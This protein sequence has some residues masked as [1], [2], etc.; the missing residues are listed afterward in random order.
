MLKIIQNKTSTW[1]VRQVPEWDYI[2]GFDRLVA[3]LW[4]ENA[5]RN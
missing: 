1:V 3:V 4:Q 2:W 5:S